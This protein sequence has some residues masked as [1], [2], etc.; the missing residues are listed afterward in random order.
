MWLKSFCRTFQ[1]FILCTGISA[2]AAEANAAGVTR[3]TL[4]PS[5]LYL[6]CKLNRQLGA[7]WPKLRY[8][9]IS[10]EECQWLLVALF[11][12]VSAIGRKLF[13]SCLFVVD[14]FI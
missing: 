11:K 14:I 9:F 4:L 8:V 5:Q 13:R 12:Q 6:A 2:I 3:I 7:V 10:G 1:H